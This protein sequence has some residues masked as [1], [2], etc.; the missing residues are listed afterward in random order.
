MNLMFKMLNVPN[1]CRR[2]NF[3]E[4]IALAKINRREY[5]PVPN[6]NPN[7][8][9]SIGNKSVE[10]LGSKIRFSS[11]LKTFPLLTS[12]STRFHSTQFSSRHN[13]YKFFFVQL[14]YYDETNTGIAPL[15][16][17]IRPMS[18]LRA[19]VY[20]CRWPHNDVTV[21]SFWQLYCKRIKFDLTNWSQFF[22]RLSCYWSWISS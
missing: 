6:T 2:L 16:G 4:W 13:D 21:A 14:L 7:S 8:G 9:L 12:K 11:V 17:N 5:F 19:M 10:T 22:L 15:H 1:Y 3:I 20:H 18:D